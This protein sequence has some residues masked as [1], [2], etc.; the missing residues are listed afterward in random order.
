M[1][2][3]GPFNLEMRV[4]G[5]TMS[6]S[7]TKSAFNRLC[8]VLGLPVDVAYDEYCHYL[9]M[10]VQH[11]KQSPQNFTAWKTAL[12]RPPRG[13]P[14][15]GKNL[16]QL[17]KRVGAWGASTSGCE[18][19]FAKQRETQGLHRS[20]MTEEHVNVDAHIMAKKDG[21]PFVTK[22]DKDKFIQ[23]ARAVWSSK[24]GN[25][26]SR[27]KYPSRL[28]GRTAKLKQNTAKTETAWL[29][30]RR[31]DVHVGTRQQRVVRQVASVD[32]HWTAGHEKEV[33]FQKQKQDIAKVQAF[34]DGALLDHEITADLA[35]K[36]QARDEKMAELYVERHRDHQKHALQRRVHTPNLMTSPKNFYVHDGVSTPALL[37]KIR[38]DRHFVTTDKAQADIFVVED[39]VTP[40][41]ETSWFLSLSGGIA[42]TQEYLMSNGKKGLALKYLRAMR[43]KRFFCMTDK[44]AASHPGAT[45]AIT[46]LMGKRW[47]N[48]KPLTAAEMQA[49]KNKPSTKVSELVV[50]GAPE[51]M[52]NATFN[53]IKFKFSGLAALSFVRKIDHPASCLNVCG[54]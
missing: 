19:S 34:A 7:F 53:G 41:E 12:S 48:W 26:R 15:F 32:E 52:T 44:F 13:S 36:K 23:K 40:G 30:R 1:Q 8:G 31:M 51:E 5:M 35:G 4:K 9:P 54:A 16:K 18:H 43:T 39:V 46:G 37:K 28:M 45:A 21:D 42:C 29:K 6:E 49:E 3:L 50:F 10:A 14:A 20:E 17:V 2:A 33:A 47:S 22:G 11:Y 25:A 38:V 27:G 24:F